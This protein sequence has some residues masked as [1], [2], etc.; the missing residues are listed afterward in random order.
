MRQML[1]VSLFLYSLKYI[2]DRKPLKYIVSILIT[3]LFHYSSIFLLALV[4][5]A[6]SK[7][8]Y[9]GRNINSV[10]LV[11][12]IVSAI[13]AIGG[14]SFDVASIFSGMGSYHKYLTSDNMI[15]SKAVFNLFFNFFAVCYFLFK[16]RESIGIYDIIFLFG[17]ICL[18]FSVPLN[19]LLRFSYYFTPIYC[20]FVPTMLLQ[21]GDSNKQLAKPIFWGTSVYY[22]A[23]LIISYINT[24]QLMGS[25]MYEWSEFF[26]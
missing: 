17:C 21:A 23:V 13:M 10:L 7:F 2:A 1:A 19:N 24:S 14:A 5:F 8:K 11:I 12:W 25:Q 26:R 16:K 9:N 20:A 4:P 22:V 6:Y 18:N 15:G 3:A